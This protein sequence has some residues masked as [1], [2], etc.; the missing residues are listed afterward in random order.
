MP[1]ALNGFVCGASVLSVQR[2]NF[3][4]DLLPCKQYTTEVTALPSSTSYAVLADPVV[5]IQARDFH[6]HDSPQLRHLSLNISVYTR[7][8]RFIYI[9]KYVYIDGCI[10][11]Y[12]LYIYF[13]IYLCMYICSCRCWWHLTAELGSLFPQRHSVTA[14]FLSGLLHSTVTVNIRSLLS[15]KYK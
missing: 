12:Y 10:Q 7:L 2:S 4:P 11:I 13:Y 9:Y 3:M 8:Y 15:S 5:A 1:Q 14:V 6:A